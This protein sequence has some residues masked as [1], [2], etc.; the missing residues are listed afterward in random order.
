M[1][2]QFAVFHEVNN[3]MKAGVCQDD[4]K[5]DDGSGCFSGDTSV[6]EKFNNNY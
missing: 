6:F 5:S 3:V 1:F 2:K 4:T